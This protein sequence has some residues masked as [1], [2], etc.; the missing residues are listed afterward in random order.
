[1]VEQSCVT[2]LNQPGKLCFYDEKYKGLV[3]SE[4]KT[5]LCII[6]RKPKQH[7]I[8]ISKTPLWTPFHEHQYMMIDWIAA[9]QKQAQQNERTLQCRFLCHKKSFPGRH[10]LLVHES[11][12]KQRGI[13]CAY[14]DC[15]GRIPVD[16]TF[17]D[18][19][20]SNALLLHWRNSC[21]HK[22]DYCWACKDD[23]R[24][25]DSMTMKDLAS[26]MEL[27]LRV[28]KLRHDIMRVVL[29][30]GMETFLSLIEEN[31]KVS[32]QQ[33]EVAFQKLKTTLLEVDELTQEEDDQLMGS[34]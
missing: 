33:V 23:G 5:D 27:H 31:S 14:D 32:M 30:A 10:A 1:M 20:W 8:N 16:F 7:K 9:N 22:Q 3:V 34:A 12:C 19:I 17:L 26:H 29:G 24:L 28:L 13:S 2:F 25:S 4:A 15:D 18:F 11:S 21:K 6:C